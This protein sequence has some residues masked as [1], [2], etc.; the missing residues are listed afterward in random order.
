MREKLRADGADVDRI[1]AEI[2]DIVIKTLFSCDQTVRHSYRAAYP[3]HVGGSACVEILGF[4]ILLDAE[5][6]PWLLEVNRC[7]RKTCSAMMLLYYRTQFSKKNPFWTLGRTLCAVACSRPPTS[8]PFQGCAT[9]VRS[10][11]RLTHQPLV[12]FVVFLSYTVAPSCACARP[13]P[14]SPDVQHCQ[15]PLIHYDSSL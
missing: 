6:R 12:L 8:L 11:Y 2:N 3:N 14:A 10:M 15:V 13:L 1:D 9:I 7:V 4:D 5:L